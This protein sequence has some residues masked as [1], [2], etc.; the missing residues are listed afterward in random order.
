MHR[1]CRHVPLIV[2][3]FCHL[4]LTLPP[5]FLSAC[6]SME[7]E[8]IRIQIAELIVSHRDRVSQGYRGRYQAHR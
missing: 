7:N 5:R 1:E 8:E 3:G 4:A 2:S 6:R